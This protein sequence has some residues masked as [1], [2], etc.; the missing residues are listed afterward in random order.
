MEGSKHLQ[1]SDKI[2]FN[3]GTYTVEEAIDTN[4]FLV[5]ELSNSGQLCL[6]MGAKHYMKE[7]LQDWMDVEQ[8]FREEQ[9]KAA[10]LQE[11]KKSGLLSNDIY[12][13]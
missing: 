4:P 1:L 7:V 12:D 10:W 2:A 5:E 3:R 6:A 13:S 11:E 8:I 9:R